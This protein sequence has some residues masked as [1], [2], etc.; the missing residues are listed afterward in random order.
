MT[1]RHGS[2]RK[3]TKQTGCVINRKLQVYGIPSHCLFLKRTR[4]DLSSEQCDLET[5]IDHEESKNA[6]SNGTTG[7]SLAS[8]RY[9]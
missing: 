1:V 8:T 6:T 4:G 2:E 5:C 9:D 7:L 3:Q